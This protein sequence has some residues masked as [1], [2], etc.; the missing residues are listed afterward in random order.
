MTLVTRPGESNTTSRFEQ[1]H[2]IIHFGCF[3]LTIQ[4][5]TFFTVVPATHDKT[6][7]TDQKITTKG[8]K[9]YAF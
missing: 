9:L 6:I 8:K 3:N 4:E 2:N 5:F 7:V 1:Y